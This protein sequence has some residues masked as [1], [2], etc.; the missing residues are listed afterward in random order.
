MIVM[1][2]GM[3]LD[4]LEKLAKQLIFKTLSCYNWVILIMEVEI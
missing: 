1:L 2:N 3:L 4:S